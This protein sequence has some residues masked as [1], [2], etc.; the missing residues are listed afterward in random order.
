MRPLKLRARHEGGAGWEIHARIPNKVDCAEFTL[1]DM[2]FQPIL[3]MRDSFAEE[4][5]QVKVGYAP[6]I[7]FAPKDWTDMIGQTFT[8]M[9]EAWNA[10]YGANKDGHY[11]DK[12]DIH[13]SLKNAF[14]D[15][16]YCP[17]CG[18]VLL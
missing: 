2:A 6:W 16:T 11:C 1:K 4:I 5:L 10:K 13:Q 7:Q 15:W 9:V 8:E 3:Q 18:K 14:P 12:Q 17:H